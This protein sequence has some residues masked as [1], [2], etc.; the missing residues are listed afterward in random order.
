MV[1][2]LKLKTLFKKKKKLSSALC[3][4]DD[5]M[6]SLVNF[7]ISSVL[8][9]KFRKSVYSVNTLND[10]DNK[11]NISNLKTQF[12]HLRN[13]NFPPFRNTEITLLEKIT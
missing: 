10:P 1:H 3:N 5:L 7:E 2:Q 6:S 11:I 12:L 9:N 13:I 4:L 8:S